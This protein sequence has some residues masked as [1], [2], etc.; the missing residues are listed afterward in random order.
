MAQVLDAKKNILPVFKSP[1]NVHSQDTR[2][3]KTILS[4]S[5]VE[6]AFLPFQMSIH[7]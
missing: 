4:V 5:G 7:I 3:Q 1:F 2:Y 6:M